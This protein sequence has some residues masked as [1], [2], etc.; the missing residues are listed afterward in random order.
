MTKLRIDL[1]QVEVRPDKWVGM[2]PSKVL[3]LYGQGEYWI[4]N[5]G[6]AQ[7]IRQMDTDYLWTLLEFIRRNAPHHL[8]KAAWA[9]IPMGA[10][11]GL[12][13]EWERSDAEWATWEV[14]PWTS[15]LVRGICAELM[16]RAEYDGIF[17]R[18]KVYTQEEI[19]RV[20]DGGMGT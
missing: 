18:I 19:R 5:Y 8:Y 16:S 14:R 9:M 2:T 15:P 12:E 3:T 7:R 10:V 20:Y 13:A 11:S 1:S 6:V 17:P 4:D